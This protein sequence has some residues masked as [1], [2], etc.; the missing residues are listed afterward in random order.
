[1]D[2]IVA[3]RLLKTRFEHIS[4]ER[5]PGAELPPGGKL[6]IEISSSTTDTKGAAN[7]IIA[8]VELV[9]VGV[10]AAAKNRDEF[11]FKVRIACAGHYDWPRLDKRPTLNDDAVEVLCLPIYT[12]AATEATRLV[13]SFGLGA[14]GLPGDLRIAK[15]EEA[16]LKK[17]KPLPKRSSTKAKATVTA[18]RKKA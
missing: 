9:V 14:V 5:G 11:G 12:I 3:S 8:R 15:D 1:M 6:E 2:A 18:A 4:V 16:D 7:Q 13:S 10:P 17:A